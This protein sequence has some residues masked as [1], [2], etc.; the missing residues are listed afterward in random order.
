M[1]SALARPSWLDSVTFDDRGL[2]PC[3][4]Q[5]RVSAE[6][7]MLAYMNQASLERTIT[8]GQTWFYSRS[9]QGL[10]NKGATSGAVQ[11][12]R[13]LHL[14]CDG[15]TILAIVDQ[16]GDGACH[17]G[18]RTCFEPSGRVPADGATPRHVL[19]ALCETLRARDRDRPEG[20]YTTKLLA[21]GVDRIGKKVGEEAT[22]VVIAAK[23]AAEG[24]GTDE[25]A[26][27]SAD[28]LY[29]LLV[30]WRSVGLE[31]RDVVT[32]LERRR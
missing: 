2:V 1:S 29:H 16:A 31:A 17:T 15:D 19:A 9:R 27:E 30:L 8:T 6:V 10:W 23:N 25:L 12:V 7:L 14:D 24:R 13:S 18:A 22:E 28:L 4:V 11:T 26:E 3:V 20:S 21:G 32:A 5:D